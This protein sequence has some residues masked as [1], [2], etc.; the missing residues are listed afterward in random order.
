MSHLKTLVPHQL[1][2]DNYPIWRN[3]IV[4]LFKAN[5]FEHFLDPS[6]HPD[7][8]DQDEDARTFT[9]QN[10]AAAICSTISA[11][12]IPYIMHLDS[13]F[14]IWEALQTRFQS[15]NRSKVMQLKNELHNITMKNMTMQTYLTEIKKIVDNIASAGSTI[16]TEDIILH[17]LNGLPTA[18]QSFKTAIRTLQTPLKLDNLYAML[19]SEEIHI[20]TD[21][22]R[23]ATQQEPTTALYANRG[24]GRRGRGR[25]QSFSSTAPKQ[26]SKSSTQCQICLKRGHTADA[27][28]HRH[29]PNYT[30]P[31]NTNDTNNALLA[32]TEA[33]STDWYLDSGASAHMTNRNDQLSQGSCYH[34]SDQVM[35]G[36]G[37]SILIAHSGTGLLPTPDRKLILSKLL[38][39]PS[40][41]HNLLSISNL[42][43]DNQISITFTPNGFTFKDLQNNKVLLIGP[44]KQGLYPIAIKKAV[45]STQA[46]SAVAASTTNWH[47]RLGHPHHRIIQHISRKHPS[48]HISQ[49]FYNCVSCKMCKSHKLPFD[50]STNRTNKPLQLLHSDVWGPSPV[51]THHGFRYYLLIID[52]YS[53][54]C[55]LFPLVFKSDVVQHFIRFIAFIEKQTH[56]KVK[57]IRTDGGGEYINHQFQSYLRSNGIHHQVSCPCTPEQN[58]VA[59]RKHRH[60][61]DTTKTLLQTASIPLNY[62]YEAVDTA[63]YLINR[64][65][66]PTNQNH[67]PL[68][69]MFN[70]SPDY[71][72]MRTFGCACFPLLP[73]HSFNKLQ[74]KSATCVF[75]GYSDKHKGY[76]CFNQEANTTTISRH[77]QFIENLFPFQQQ[78]SPLTTPMQALPTQL[79]LPVSKVQEDH[80]PAPTNSSNISTTLPPPLESTTTSH[81]PTRIP[82]ALN[83]DKPSI[84]HTIQHHMTTRSKTGSLKPISRLNLLHHV[85]PQ[86][87]QNV[88]TSY[89]EAIKHPEWRHAMSEEF[90]ALQQ[91]GTW[92]LVTPPSNASI[93]GCKWTFRKKFNSDGTVS[94]F[95]ARL[96]AQGNRQEHGLDYEETFSPVAKLPTIRV[97]FTVALY[98]GWQVQQ[99]D[100]T[101]AFLHGSLEETVFMRQP[102]GFEDTM[103][104]DHVCCLKKAIYGL[105][106]APRQWY[107]TFTTHLINIG[108]QHSKADPSLLVYRRQRT[109][110]FLLVYVDDILITGN[111]KEAITNLLQNLHSKFTMKQ[112][113]LARHFLGITIQSTPDKYFLSQQSYAQSLLQ[114]TN[115]HKCNSLSNPSST[116]QPNQFKQDNTIPDAV[117]YRK[118]TGALQYLT[119]TRPDIAH[120][121]NTLSQHMHD[122]QPIHFHLLKRLLR[123]IRGTINFGLPITKSSMILRTFSDADWAGDPITR[124]STSGFCTFL[125]DTLVSW[126]VKKQN[127]VSRSSTESEYR[128]LAAATADT[129]WLKRLLADFDILHNTPVAVYCDNTSEIALA[130]NPVFHARTK[131]IEID[132]RFIRDHI[133]NKTIRLLPISTVDQIADIFTKPLPTLRFKQLRSQLTIREESQV[134]GGIL[135]PNQIGYL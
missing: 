64:F 128:A 2:S 129:I 7:Q 73:P 59:E 90:A 115:L 135:A 50:L 131:H 85:A 14:E 25:N 3:Q 86:E 44:C 17:I 98:N 67:S 132:Q 41:S 95:K 107:T 9:D 71:A 125:G 1:S 12:V 35:V 5:G 54:Y 84:K 34:G 123:Y 57:A 75:L 55:W 108:F 104:P 102:K 111:D 118:I 39:I 133:S 70:I 79:L 117:T 77:V 116:K 74:P 66:S 42:V 24:R 32:S 122:P 45:T 112:L 134:L 88:P 53:R 4:K 11:P 60:I 10:L 22:L 113:G 69:L 46:L 15:S 48:L 52:D 99:L 119:I 130:N 127:T 62:W 65:P 56:H 92:D 121:T 94:R 8:E 96:V 76:K 28:W 110:L 72:H 13:T 83:P 100:V 26:G 47:Q 21:T 63:V 16:D 93:L 49:K 114:Q 23:L 81:S 78:S 124:K 51:T 80:R 36:D 126:T 40:I 29:D 91:Q 87:T 43:S 105:K 101:N 33:T 120:T 82:S 89:S 106:Q 31:R 30:T 20:Q 18:Y 6:I 109:Q 38:H 97:L 61:L 37:R 103:S 19:I 27:C 68:Q 58:G